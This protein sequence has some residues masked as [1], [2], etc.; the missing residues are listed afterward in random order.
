MVDGDVPFFGYPF[1][2]LRGIPAMRYQGEEVVTTEIEYL[3][4]VTPRWTIAVFAG[5]AR[6]SSVS[7][8]GAGSETVTAGGA[9]F[10]YRIARKLGLQVGMDVARGPEETA[11][12]LTVGNAW[13]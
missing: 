9:G 3:W 5:A 4:G 13:Q 8:F 6:T 1:V 11:Y 12:Y 7:D 10:R 2:N